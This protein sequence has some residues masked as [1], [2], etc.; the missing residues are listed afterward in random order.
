MRVRGQQPWP[1]IPGE[2]AHLA[3]PPAFEQLQGAGWLEEE[4]RAFGLAVVDF[5]ATRR[6]KL[7]YDNGVVSGM[8]FPPAVAGTAFRVKFCTITESRIK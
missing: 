1:E 2:G 5:L 4:V 3:G 6:G 8:F 7:L